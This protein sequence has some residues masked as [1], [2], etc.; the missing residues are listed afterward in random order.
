MDQPTPAFFD[1]H[2]LLEQSQPRA[3]GGWFWYG[4]G[5]FLLIVMV[6]AYAT[7]QSPQLKG[8]I[9][10]AS[11]LAMI[12][13]MV[14]MAMITSAAVRRQR[15]EM[16]RVEA[17]EELIQLRRRPEA[18]TLSQGMLSQPTRTPQARVQAL[19]F[20]SSILARYH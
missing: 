17:L 2:S 19:L 20:F 15:D 14:A 3:R 12:G 8:L 13:L 6:S 7:S 1:V 4:V 10:L 16:R 18:A 11:M 5:V 9:D